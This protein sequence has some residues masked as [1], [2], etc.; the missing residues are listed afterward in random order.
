[1]LG[2]TNGHGR[3]WLVVAALLGA[4][5]A[6]FGG[7]NLHGRL[8]T[9]DGLSVLEVWGS[10]A[11]AGYAQGWLVGDRIPDL[12]DK[13]L[14]D[15]TMLPNLGMYEG[16]LLRSTRIQF[17][18]DADVLAEIEGIVRGATDRIG[19]KFRSEK[20]DRMLTVDDLLVA[21]TIADLFGEK[22]SSFSVW[23]D[24]TE[25]GQTLT[26]RNLDFPSTPTMARGAIVVIRA[27]PDGHGW[28]S[29]TWPGMVGVVT[30]MSDRGVCIAM[31]DANA[32]HP[33][34]RT[35][36][37]KPRAITL[38]KALEAA[39]P[40]SFVDDIAGVFR[41]SP[42]YCG[43]NIHTSRPMLPGNDA[44][45]AAVLEYDGNARDAGVT[46]RGPAA[47]SQLAALWCTNDVRTRQE[48]RKCW[49][50]DKISK[51]LDEWNAA[52]S[53]VDVEKAFGLLH[54]IRQEISLHSVV[55]T[56]ADRTMRI[57][58]PGQIEGTATIRLADWLKRPRVANTGQAAAGASSA[59]AP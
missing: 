26:A 51:Q 29:L 18:W 13:F 36:G 20:L 33:N 57:R 5:G 19:A 46:I 55:F 30:A 43:N 45:P 42:V 16:M 1:M 35:Y 3:A 39:K 15:P 6:A 50:F 4:A 38:R 49:R 32:L 14:L 34:A 58:I 31:H 56:P 37:F 47:P 21:N 52:H 11:E 54:E 22:C 28:A 27:L 10:P 24:L 53:K 59:A 9:H 44:P 7:E 48:P 25:D 12:F 40:E 23:G 2:F 17:D 41:K 8:S